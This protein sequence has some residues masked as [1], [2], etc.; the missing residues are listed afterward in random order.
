MSTG[1]V[2]LN[3][4]RLINILHIL[5]AHITLLA[6]FAPKSVLLT[7]TDRVNLSRAGFN[8]LGLS[9]NYPHIHMALK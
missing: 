8:P 1:L 9:V 6:T 3:S 2:Y 4:W 7:E 5:A